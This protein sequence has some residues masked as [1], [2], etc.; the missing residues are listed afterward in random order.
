MPLCRWHY[1]NPPFS[2]ASHFFFLAGAGSSS[3]LSERSSAGACFS[4]AANLLAA[5]P[6]PFASLSARACWSRLSP[7]GLLRA[8]L[9][10]LAPDAAAVTTPLF[11][12]SLPTSLLLCLPL[13]SLTFSSASSAPM[14]TRCIL[15]SPSSAAAHLGPVLGL[16]GHA[17][18]HSH[19]L[20]EVVLGDAHQV[21]AARCAHHAPAA[22]GRRVPLLPHVGPLGELAVLEAEMQRAVAQQQARLALRLALAVPRD[23]VDAPLSVLLVRA[24]R[25]AGTLWSCAACPARPPSTSPCR[26]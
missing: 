12:A 18:H 17:P 13:T 2:F 26:S 21:E 5:G 4:S 15:A 23:G 20:L 19:P 24:S 8:E 25:C 16:H 11:A 6:S 14:L 7:F 22:L 3:L 1:H 10:P 9:L